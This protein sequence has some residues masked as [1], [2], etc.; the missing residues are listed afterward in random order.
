MFTNVINNQCKYDAVF[1][2]RVDLK[3]LANDLHVRKNMILLV[4]V[5]RWKSCS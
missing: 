3:I 1:K 5:H 2:Y 4:V